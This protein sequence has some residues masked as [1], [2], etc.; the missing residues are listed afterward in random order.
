MIQIRSSIFETNSSSTHCLVYKSKGPSKID[1]EKIFD[2]D[3]NND[4]KW[5]VNFGNYGW[6]RD[7]PIKGINE[8][9]NYLMTLISYKVLRIAYL[10][11][12]YF[13]K[14][15][16]KTGQERWDD[17][18]K[19]LDDSDD[20][21][22]L[23]ELFI[24]HSN[25]EFRGFNYCWWDDDEIDSCDIGDIFRNKENTIDHPF[26]HLYNYTDDYGYVSS[27]GVEAFSGFGYVDHQSEELLYDLIKGIGFETYLFSSD[28]M[29]VIDN[30]NH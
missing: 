29:I 14:L 16:G 2:Y 13:A 18:C 17:A 22:T 9:L 8:K 10:S 11:D 6:T 5:D 24:K 19:I 28:I 25:G 21:K 4:K 15:N 12:N 7:V 3:L 23:K 26:W 27:K 20:V 1:E 30:D